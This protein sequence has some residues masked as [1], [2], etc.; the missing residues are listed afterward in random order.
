MAQLEVISFP[1]IT[2]YLGEEA[3]LHLASFQRF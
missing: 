2:C 1:P 3:S